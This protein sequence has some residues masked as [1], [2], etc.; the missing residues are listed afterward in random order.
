M[1]AA[2]GFIVIMMTMLGG[3]GVLGIAYKNR[4]S[5][6]RWLNAPY[7]SEDDREVRLK[8]RREDIDREIA[9]LAEYN[10]KHNKPGTES[11]P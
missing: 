1:E 6:K 8:R 4:A 10:A 5:I 9:W 2:I 3:V 7:Y 11:T